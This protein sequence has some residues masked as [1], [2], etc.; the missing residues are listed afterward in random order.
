MADRWTP[1]NPI[2][3]QV[4]LRNTV[5]LSRM[6]TPSGNITRIEKGDSREARSV[7]RTARKIKD[8]RPPPTGAQMM[9]RLLAPCSASVD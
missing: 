5:R 6:V 7:I 2:G 8:A 4:V 3:G 9:D 1:A